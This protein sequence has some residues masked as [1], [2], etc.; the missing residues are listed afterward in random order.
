MQYHTVGF[1]LSLA[2]CLSEIGRTTEAINRYN[3]LLSQDPQN[4]EA[5]VGLAEVYASIKRNDEAED[6]LGKVNDIRAKLNRALP[7]QE[8]HITGP[9]SVA[10]AF[11]QNRPAT[12][13]V[14]G[15]SFR[16]TPAER[17]ERERKAE[18]YAK[19]RIGQIRRF[20]DGMENG[21]PVAV[22][23]WVRSAQD[24]ISMFTSNK[25]LLPSDRS[26]LNSRKIDR[27]LDE[28][29]QLLSSQIHEN[30][31]A[32]EDDQTVKNTTRFRDISF[33]SWFDI[34]MQCALLLAKAGNTEDAYSILKSAREVHVF[35][36][37]PVRE[38]ITIMVY[39][40]CTFIAKDPRTA[41]EIIR[42]YLNSHQFHN[43]VFR[44]YGSMM[45]S[46][47][48]AMETFNST[49]NQKF[50]LRQLKAMDSLLEK[51]AISGA[52]RIVNSVSLRAEQPLLLVLYSHIMLLGRSYVPC[53]T[54]LNRVQHIVPRDTMVLLTAGLVHIHRALQRQTTNRHLQI[55]QGLSYLLEY[56]DVRSKMGD[57]ETQEA[58]FN[59]GR[60]FHML[61]LPSFAVEYYQKVLNSERVDDAY[62]LH[63]EAAY[64]LHLI[65]AVAGNSKLARSVLDTH[66]VI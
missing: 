49:N 17:A 18:A 47:N 66:L 24:L 53:L 13:K 61:G 41:N 11:I 30:D 64:N 55:V 44:L 23:E 45:S 28:R 50:F 16:L 39:L 9:E 65:Y 43:D 40:S 20:Q 3:Q 42:L 22:S 1:K 10:A 26:K 33:D 35:H 12:T 21:N 27:T 38:R 4:I 31:I 57:L 63:R 32:D 52:A 62:D 14:T 37:D 7:T 8:G 34:F 60:T 48:L 15:K 25:R 51:K 6:L 59:L 5:M 2:K 56:Y 36:L 29:I 46:G 19:E 58:N 54:Y